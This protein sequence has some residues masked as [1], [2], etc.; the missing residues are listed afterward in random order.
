MKIN[1]S[2]HYRFQQYDL[3]VNHPFRGNRFNKAKDFFDEKRLFSSSSVSYVEPDPANREDLL[4]IHSDNYVN[5][6]FQL[7]E[8]GQPY[9]LDTPVSTSIVEG[10]MYIIGGVLKI[11]SSV[12]NDE[13]SRGVA[14]GGGFH[15]AGKNYGGGFCIFN[16]IGVAIK[17]LKKLLLDGNPVFYIPIPD[18]KKILNKLKSKG[19]KLN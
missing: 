12:F 13:I 1:I 6:I 14:I 9:D 19:V 11:G 15:H 4:L 18:E 10:L 7:A 8:V 2:Y 17:Y 3:G 5:Q 16:D